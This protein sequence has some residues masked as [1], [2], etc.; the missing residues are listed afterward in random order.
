MHAIEIKYR[1]TGK[2]INDLASRTVEEPEAVFA[3][4][5]GEIEALESWVPLK[6]GF[7]DEIVAAMEQLSILK[8]ETPS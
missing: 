8:G 3:F 4:T 6:D 1:K 7:H 2:Y 5:L